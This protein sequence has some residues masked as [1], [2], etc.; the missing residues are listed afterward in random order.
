MQLCSHPAL[1]Q[2]RGVTSN[3][4]PP[5]HALPALPS[6]GEAEAPGSRH[7]WKRAQRGCLPTPAMGPTHHLYP[8]Q[9]AAAC[10]V[11]TFPASGRNGDKD[12]LLGWVGAVMPQGNFCHCQI[13]FHS[14]PFH[15]KVFPS[16]YEFSCF[17]YTIPSACFFVSNPLYNSSITI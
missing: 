9:G 14:C 17:F 15:C 4:H 6:C 7:R 12:I 3:P 5:G 2:D 11:R 16:S 13:R 10:Q 8:L 1:P